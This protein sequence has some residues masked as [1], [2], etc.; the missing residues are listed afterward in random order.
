[1]ASN[2]QCPGYNIPLSQPTRLEALHSRLKG[3]TPDST[4]RRDKLR[5]SEPIQDDIVREVRDGWDSPDEVDGEVAESSDCGSDGTEVNNLDVGGLLEE[6][7]ERIEYVTSL[8]LVMDFGTSGID[9]RLQSLGIQYGGTGTMEQRDKTG[10]GSV[11]FIPTADRNNY[12][13][14]SG[15]LKAATE[16]KYEP[17]NIKTL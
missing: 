5:V 10:C 4:R 7:N 1:M 9:N 15:L 2:A 6:L 14:E 3:V 12:G 13:E 8:P 16:A 17:Q 11:A